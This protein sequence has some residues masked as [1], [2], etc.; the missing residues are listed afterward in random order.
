MRRSRISWSGW[1]LSVTQE[2][3]NDL[4]R[5]RIE[6]QRDLDSPTLIENDPRPYTKRRKDKFSL[7]ISPPQGNI[8]TAD[9]WNLSG[10]VKVNIKFHSLNENGTIFRANVKFKGY[11]GRSR[12]PWVNM[13]LTVTA[14]PFRD[15]YSA[16]I[17][18]ILAQW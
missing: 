3:N 4:T 15:D 14:R 6:A 18:F 9:N 12:I 17:N 2:P 16:K 5:E 10:A 13:K 1:R 7:G 8:Y 11:Q